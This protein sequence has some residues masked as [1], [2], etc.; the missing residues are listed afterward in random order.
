MFPVIVAILQS[1]QSY[2]VAY[3]ARGS[4]ASWDWLE[5]ISPCVVALSDLQK[6]FNDT[7][8]G[9][10]GLLHAEVD[11]R[12][13]I[14]SLIDCLKEYKVY[15]IHLGR[16]LSNEE[17]AK[18]VTGLG[19]HNLTTGEPSPLSDYN[20]NKTKLQKRRRMKPVSNDSD[21]ESEGELTTKHNPIPNPTALAASESQH[22]STSNL[23][24][25]SD[26]PDAPVAMSE[27]GADN[28]EDEAEP[29]TELQKILAEVEGNDEPTLQRLGEED[30]AYN[31][32]EVEV[33][34]EVSDEDSESS[35]G[36]ASEESEEE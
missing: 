9:E 32:D 29:Q 18:E 6:A 13:D 15:T 11:L 27:L 23:A 19:L 34:V 12:A 22:P 17:I 1:V 4:N 36:S 14:Q 7:L 20:N 10:Q 8:G 16:I 5:T 33:E 26:S 35:S 3:K 24:S 21:R 30:V 2:K 28:Q 25:I 31:M